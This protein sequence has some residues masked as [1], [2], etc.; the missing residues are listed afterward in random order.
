M[1]K[2]KK[3]VEEISAEEVSAD[4]KLAAAK[5]EPI[6]SE[7]QKKAD[8][9][10]SEPKPGDAPKSA[11]KPIMD[12]PEP[13][14]STATDTQNIAGVKFNWAPND[15][16]EDL[17]KKKPVDSKADPIDTKAGTVTNGDI[18]EPSEE[19]KRAFLAGEMD[20]QQEPMTVEELME[21]AELVIDLLDA[22]NSTAVGA[23]AGE[24]PDKFQLPATQRKRLAGFLA[25]VFFKYQVKM[26]PVAGLI[27][28][29]LLY[30]GLVWKMGW[31][32]K[33][34]KKIE[35]ERKAIE[36]QQ[37]KNRERKNAF[38]NKI[39]ATM[40]IERVTLKKLADRLGLEDSVIKPELELMQ[41][42]GLI[43]ADHSEVPVRYSITD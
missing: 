20:K 36:D 39:I 16:A 12:I 25:R 24:K 42:L 29:A 21:V 28:A 33:K 7:D 6:V 10:K 35:A 26:G 17:L 27:I 23:F 22:I 34:D 9:L 32:V 30:F 15:Y 11:A 43:K 3:D 38:R 40:G 8:N 1:A 4:D 13:K 5:T 41:N 2:G 18:E 37:A 14:A 19:E 31:D